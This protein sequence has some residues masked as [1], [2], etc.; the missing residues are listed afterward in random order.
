MLQAIRI[1]ITVIAPVLLFLHN[2]VYYFCQIF[3]LD[4]F[5]VLNLFHNCF[6]LWSMD[7]KVQMSKSLLTLHSFMWDGHTHYQ[8]Y[9]DVVI[10]WYIVHPPHVRGNHEEEMQQVAHEL[11]EVKMSVS[12]SEEASTES[13]SLLHHLKEEIEQMK[14]RDNFMFWQLCEMLP[15]LCTARLIY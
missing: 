12:A 1:F 9:T 11:Q 2:F 13:P 6:V 10:F 8:L 3:S 5:E 15:C 4:S 7:V 14:V